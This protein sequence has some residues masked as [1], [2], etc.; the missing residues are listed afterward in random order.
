[1]GGTKVFEISPGKVEIMVMGS[2]NTSYDKLARMWKTKAD[3]AARLRGATQYQILR[4]STGRELMG[5]EVM[6]ENSF[7]ERYSGDTTFWFPK[8]ARGV[9]RLLDPVGPEHRRIAEIQTVR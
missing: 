1:M 3:E 9:I 4:F 8:I 7:V 5:V 2:H 6:G